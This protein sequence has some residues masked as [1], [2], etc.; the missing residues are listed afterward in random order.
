[1][2]GIGVFQESDVQVIRFCFEGDLLA[3]KIVVANFRGWLH[4]TQ[5]CS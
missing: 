4:Q 1:M 3:V 5:R 2:S